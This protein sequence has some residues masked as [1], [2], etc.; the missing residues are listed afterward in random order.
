M[1][2]VNRGCWN[3]TRVCFMFLR[4]E[5][6]TF[7]EIEFD[8]RIQGEFWS[9]VRAQM[10]TPHISLQSSRLCHMARPRLASGPGRKTRGK[11]GRTCWLSWGWEVIPSLRQVRTEPEKWILLWW[12][13]R[14]TYLP[15]YIHHMF[16]YSERYFLHVSFH[17]HYKSSIVYT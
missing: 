5:R 15:L 16:I 3:N 8:S 13:G 14:N 7:G 11:T 9:P 1:A 17:E 10:S 6:D 2:W 4:Q 12:N